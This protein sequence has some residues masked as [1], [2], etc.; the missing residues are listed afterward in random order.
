M[1][2]ESIDGIAKKVS[3]MTS[4]LR[5]VRDSIGDAVPKFRPV[6]GFIKN[7]VRRIRK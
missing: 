2:K 5:E 1:F 4:D 6:R 3:E 7:R